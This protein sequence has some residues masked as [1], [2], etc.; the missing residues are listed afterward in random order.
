MT[1]QAVRTAFARQAAWCEK[2]GSPFTAAL[3]QGCA[4]H[5]TSDTA[6]GARIL[7]WPG[8]PDSAADALPLRL[9]GALHGLVLSGAAPALAALYPPN[10]MPPPGAL[11]HAVAVALQ[12]YGTAV[13][14]WLDH[15]PQTNEVT[16]CAALMAGLRVLAACCGPDMTLWEVGASAG[17]NLS[18][19]RY[20]IQTGTL[21]SG[22]ADSPVTIAPAWTGADPPGALPRI[23]ARRGVDLHPLRITDP[24][25][26]TRLLSYVWPDQQARLARLRAAVALAAADPPSLDQGDAAPWVEQHLHPGPDGKLRV[27]WHS[28]AFQY[29]PPQTQDRITRHMHGP[30]AGTAWLRFEVDPDRPGPPTLRLRLPN[31]AD[32]LLGSGSPHGHDL[33]W[34]GLPA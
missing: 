5:L 23:H 31:G 22:P 3:L 26:R 28:I 24:A 30:G 4:E 20:L 32:H 1:E 12:D 14:V 21:R 19:D 16:R 13:D 9:A 17:L 11:W 2:L 6:S 33:T 10:P 18:P 29:F 8:D 34:L 15:A 27:L 7:A 25:Q